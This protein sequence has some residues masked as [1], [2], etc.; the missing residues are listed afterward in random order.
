MAVGVVF[1]HVL[2]TDTSVT[3]PFCRIFNSPNRLLVVAAFFLHSFASL[4]MFLLHGM[5][6]MNWDPL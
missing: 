2:W 3:V 1:L 5:L 6:T 4:S